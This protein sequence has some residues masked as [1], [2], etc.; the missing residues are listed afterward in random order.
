MCVGDESEE[1]GGGGSPLSRH[2]RIRTIR[3]PLMTNVMIHNV[4][5]YP[6]SATSGLRYFSTRESNLIKIRTTHLLVF[7]LVPN[8]KKTDRK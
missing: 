8:I 7:F 4:F 6:P 3:Y 5:E 1:M 2:T